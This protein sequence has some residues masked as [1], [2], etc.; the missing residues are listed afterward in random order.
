MSLPTQDQIRA[1]FDELPDVVQEAILNTDIPSALRELHKSSNMHLDK[2]EILQRIV[3]S[4]LVGL[5]P[6]SSIAE[7]LSSELGADSEQV[8]ALV[9]ALAEKVF[10]QVREKLERE[11]G[12]PEAKAETIS[13]IEKVRRDA[14]HAEGVATTP[15][16]QSVVPGTPPAPKTDAK[17]V[18][19]PASGAYKPGEA[20][21]TRKQVADDPYREAVG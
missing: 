10:L 8:Q 5:V 18:R 19:G 20:S 2:W 16:P 17:V 9:P 4:A 15:A 13:D 7:S 11:L 12:H 14:L 3:M 21:T 1:R 6:T